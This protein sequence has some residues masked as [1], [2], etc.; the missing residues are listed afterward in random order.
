MVWTIPLFDAVSVNKA[1]KSLRIGPR[2]DIL[3]YHASLEV[4]NNWRSSHAF[5]LNTIQM[6]L[7]RKGRA[8]DEDC[9]VAQRI[10]RLSSIEHKL[11]RFPSM[12]LTQMQDIG[13]C[14]A[15]LC[16]VNCVEDL[17]RSFKSGSLKH[18]LS[19]EDNYIVSPK[20]SGYRGVHLVYRYFSDRNETF[21]N[22]KIEIQIRSQLQHAWATAVEV[23]GT[24]VRQALKSSQGQQEW[25]DFFRLMASAIAREEGRPTIPGTPQKLKD[26]QSGIRKLSRSLRAIERL[27]QY[28]HAIKVVTDSEVKARYYLLELRP[29]VNRLVVSGYN[30]IGSSNASDRYLEAEKQ[31]DPNQGDE[32]VLVSVDSIESLKKAYPNYFLDTT[33]FI[34][35]VRRWT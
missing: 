3:G 14:R 4:I 5:P 12:K 21:N 11:V 10:K 29:S 8:I 20:Q 33:N 24:L 32:A 2:Q 1:G 27:N 31:L 7:R 22:L 15:I 26:L 25:L 13:G 35:I 6:N 30:D 18:K 34:S 16:D 9:L 28:S 19:S 17:V 23:V